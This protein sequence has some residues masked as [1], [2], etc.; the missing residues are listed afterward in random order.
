MKADRMDVTAVLRNQHRQIRRA[1]ARAARP[2]R[3]R[4]RAFYQLVRLLARL[5]RTGPHG[6]GYRRGLRRCVGR[7]SPTPRGRNGRSSRC[8][9]ADAARLL[10]LEVKLAK[11]LV[12]TRP[13]PRVNGELANRLATP[14]LDPAD[15]LRDLVHR[16]RA[17]A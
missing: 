16:R 3:N 2:G 1:F 13:H 10:G 7:C 15:R 11:E 9:A 5:W 12:P 14:V 4:S 6:A 8:W 17:D